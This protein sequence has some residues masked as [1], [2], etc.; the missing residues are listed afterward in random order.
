MT[1]DKD[2]LEHMINFRATE[3]MYESLM[4]YLKQTGKTI[5]GFMRQATYDYLMLREVMKK[6]G[7]EGKIPLKK[8][9]PT[10]KVDLDQIEANKFCD[11]DSCEI[12]LIAM[13]IIN[14][15]KVEDK[16]E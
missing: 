4:A 9:K 1:E 10:I 6:N 11:G 16:H 15:K 13:E 7:F 2:R 8:S 5:S 12:P 3:K 14:K